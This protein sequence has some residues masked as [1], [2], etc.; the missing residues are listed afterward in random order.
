MNPPYWIVDSAIIFMPE[1]NDC[2]NNY[3]DI[4]ANYSMLV[5]SNYDDLNIALKNNYKYNM[6]KNNTYVNQPLNES[7][8]GLHNLRE[9][10]FSDQFNQPQDDSLS[11]LHNLQ[12]LTLSY[13]LNQYVDIPGCIKKLTILNCKSYTF[14]DYLPNG[15]E[16]LVLGY[17]FNLE[18][19]DLPSSI[20]KIKIFNTKYNKKLN[21][22]PTGLESLEIRNE[23]KIPIDREYKNL[24]IVKF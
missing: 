15:I 16:E 14:V 11:E 20:K 21:N 7:L 22:L 19:N 9:L 17:D 24:N 18:L 2:L 8:S 5:F 12:E 3:S 13:C 23:Y 6:L 1:F 4:I 10:T